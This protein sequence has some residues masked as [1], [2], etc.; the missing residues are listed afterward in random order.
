MRKQFCRFGTSNGASFGIAIQEGGSSEVRFTVSVDTDWASASREASTYMAGSPA[1]LFK[2][3]AHSWKGWQGE[4]SWT[5]LEDRVRLSATSD[6]L[7]H[8]RMEVHFRSPDY[9]DEA[10]LSVV[11]EAGQLQRMSEEIDEM[12]LQYTP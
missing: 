3:M 8:V 5:D 11:F 1:V 2:E 12:F 6:S 10:C 4:K 9:E 7:G